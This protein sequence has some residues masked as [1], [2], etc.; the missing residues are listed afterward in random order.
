MKATE[1]DP[2]PENVYNRVPNLIS[3]TTPQSRKLF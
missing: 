2:S 3:E 1:T